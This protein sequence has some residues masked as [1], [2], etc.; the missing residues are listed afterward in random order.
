MARAV[1]AHTPLSLITLNVDFFK[2]FNIHYDHEA[3]ADWL[4]QVAQTQKDAS[5]SSELHTALANNRTVIERGAA[6]YEQQGP[7]QTTAPA[8]R[9][10][11]SD[12]AGNADSALLRE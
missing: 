5:L 1:R 7:D 3:G 6:A 9:A 10:N 2:R 8:T 11:Q 4:R 12:N